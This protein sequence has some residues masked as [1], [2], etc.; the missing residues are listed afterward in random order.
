MSTYSIISSRPAQVR[1]PHGQIVSR[2]YHQLAR[3]SRERTWQREESAVPW[4]VSMGS[5]S[6]L[7]PTSPQQFKPAA[8]PDKARTTRAASV[9]SGCTTS[10]GTKTTVGRLPSRE[11]IHWLLNAGA[12]SRKLRPSKDRRPLPEAIISEAREE[13]SSTTAMVLKTTA[14]PRAYRHPTD[15]ENG[16]DLSKKI[17]LEAHARLSDDSQP[18]GAS[19]HPTSGEP[20]SPVLVKTHHQGAEDARAALKSA[21]EMTSDVLNFFSQEATITHQLSASRAVKSPV[22]VPSE[23]TNKRTIKLRNWSL[24][25]SGGRRISSNV[26]KLCNDEVVVKQWIYVEG[27]KSA[28]DGGELW[29]SSF[30]FTRL[31]SHTVQTTSGSSYQLEGSLDVHTTMNHGLSERVVEAF[32]DGFPENW[33]EILCLELAEKEAAGSSLQSSQVASLGQVDGDTDIFEASHPGRMLEATKEE[34]DKSDPVSSSAI[35]IEHVND[36]NDFKPSDDQ[37]VKD[38]SIGFVGRP[39]TVPQD[40]VSFPFQREVSFVASPSS[41]E[42]VIGRRRADSPATKP[43]NAL[44]LPSPKQLVTPRA[45][46]TKPTASSSSCSSRASR[47]SKELNSLGRSPFGNIRIVKETMTALEL[48]SPQL[49]AP[50]CVE[51]SHTPDPVTPQASAKGKRKQPSSTSEGDVCDWDVSDRPP[52]SARRSRRRS[53]QSVGKWWIIAPGIVKTEETKDDFSLPTVVSDNHVGG[54]PSTKR[55]RHK[56]RAVQPLIGYMASSNTTHNDAKRE[57]AGNIFSGKVISEEP[58]HR[59]INAAAHQE[60]RKDNT[61]EGK[62]DRN[63]FRDDEG[64]GNSLVLTQPPTQAGRHTRGSRNRQTC[65]TS[66]EEAA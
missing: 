64:L 61:D 13:D 14:F 2:V 39:R 42:G 7:G 43:S 50:L 1:P 49:P 29:H 26:H 38:H 19:A 10:K 21:S 57:E 9:M 37:F 20:M 55:G 60:L 62:G 35:V 34:P 63:F 52:T 31:G 18:S 46:T 56:N 23:P 11:E 30:I 24:K 44:T 8:Q 33:V 16:F 15:F 45:K 32:T 66:L 5:S 22:V 28:A 58:S 6:S 41:A 48:R 53:G 40:D 51:D 65:S 36:Q 4:S 47:L 3:Q 17:Q 12:S 59:N 27:I 54:S 25:L